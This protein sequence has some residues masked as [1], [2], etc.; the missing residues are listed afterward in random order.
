MSD[1]VR[2]EVSKKNDYWIPKHRYYELKHFCQQYPEWKAACASID[3]YAI[4]RL[5]GER[6]QTSK[7]TDPTA[8]GACLQIIYSEHINMIDRVAKQTDP[9]LAYFI[10]KGVTEGYSYEALHLLF[11]M[12]C[13]RET[14]YD[15][16]RKFFYYLHLARK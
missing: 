9:E 6:V 7:Q 3:G 11:D 5:T 4:S 1:T 12:P 15:R 2:P 16:Y 13:G 14:Y 10:R 8:D